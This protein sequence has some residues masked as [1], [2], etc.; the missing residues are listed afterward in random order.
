MSTTELTGNPV[1]V[2]WD[3]VSRQL[4]AELGEDVY[5]S[6]FASVHA[7]E[8]LKDG[9]FT[10]SVP[11]RFLRSWIPN[12]YGPK[13]LK[14]LQ[15]EN[16]GIQ[17]LNVTTRTPLLRQSTLEPA[18]IPSNGNGH[19]LPAPKSKG[20]KSLQEED[21]IGVSL[22]REFSLS[23]FCTGPSNAL[24]AM[25]ATAMT[26]LT[27]SVHLRNPIY[28][29]GV[30]GSGKTHLLQGL[31]AQAQANGR[32]AIYTTAH[33]FLQQEAALSVHGTSLAQYLLGMEI[34]ALDD[35]GLLTSKESLATFAKIL[36]GLLA[37]H[38]LILAGVRAP[39][40]LKVGDEHTRSRIA[41]GMICEIAMPD[42]ALRSA[43]LR[44]QV[45]RAQYL[46]PSFSIPEADFARIVSQGWATPRDL[47]GVVSKLVLHLSVTGEKQVTPE[48]MEQVVWKSLAASM[49]PQRVRVEDII[50][51]VAKHYNISRTDLLSHRRTR[52]IS[53]PRQIAMYLAKV[54]TM[55]SLPE[56]GR[57]FGGRDH[58]TV[59]HAV[60]KVEGL[61]QSDAA[62]SD[63]IENLKKD[64]TP[65]S[66]NFS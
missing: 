28:F 35:I 15:A 20:F 56:I 59:L 11:T 23:T 4:R 27:E 46:N 25:T 44:A 42:V 24:A 63:E 55:K 9:V 45:Q 53:R 2:I 60:R 21:L 47:C 30:N 66:F 61:M 57:R 8:G 18:A 39:G 16:V 14:I 12:H 29:Y 41:A 31:V 49:L 36:D 3:R 40:D 5:D 10:L 52:H 37:R 26:R 7:E 64:L 43:I 33:R 50:R 54:L 62:F 19:T 1:P 58:T 34:L 65:V 48:I 51:F 17:K 38:R 6:W 22:D 32:K 13:I